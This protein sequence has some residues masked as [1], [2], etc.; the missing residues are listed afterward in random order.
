M[1]IGSRIKAARERQNIKQMELAEMI[2]T[3]PVTISRWE[4]NINTPD[5]N[6]LKKI[7]DKLNTTVAYLSEEVNTPDR[8]DKVG[9]TEESKPAEQTVETK[10]ETPPKID[11]Q[12]KYK[13]DLYYKFPNGGEISLPAGG[14]YLKLFERL[15]TQGLA[16]QNNNKQTTPGAKDS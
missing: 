1:S 5:T 11:T 8:A 4:R 12:T 13:N 15:V 2:D 6:T 3:H 7:A 16:A 10:E 14:E 9:K